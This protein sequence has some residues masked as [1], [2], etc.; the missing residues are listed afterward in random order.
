MLGLA[1]L[2]LAMLSQPSRGARWVVVTCRLVL[3]SLTP[4]RHCMSLVAQPLSRLSHCL[5][6]KFGSPSVFS[7]RTR[8]HPEV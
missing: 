3:S 4:L 5:S 2:K 8:K 6:Y 7:R 1:P